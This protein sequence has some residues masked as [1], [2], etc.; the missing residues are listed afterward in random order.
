PENLW[1]GFGIPFDPEG[2]LSTFPAVVN[3]VAGYIAGVFIQRS[4]NTIKT[5]WK[6]TVVGIIFIILAQIWSIWFPVNKPLWTSS[7]VVLSVGW[8]LILLS[9]LILFIEILKVKNW[10][11]FFEVFGRNPLFIFVLSGLVVM[12]MNVFYIEGTASKTY[13]YKNYFL[14]WLTPY[15][16][17]L[18]F[19]TIYMLLMWLVGYFMDKRKIYIKV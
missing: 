15:N 5:I 8:V 14:S 19:A 13:I 9:F 12:W 18:L 3:V 7:Y 10:T 6:L 17:S 2:I 16:A 11:Y 4:G 1:K